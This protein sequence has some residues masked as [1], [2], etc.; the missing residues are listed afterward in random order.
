MPGGGGVQ[1]WVNK[2]NFF[3]QFCQKANQASW[4]NI[5]STKKK[6]LFFSELQEVDVQICAKFPHYKSDPVDN[7]S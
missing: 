6:Y 3:L 1:K 4:Q 2:F 7:I 5:K